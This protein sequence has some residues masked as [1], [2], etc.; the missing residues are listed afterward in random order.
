V[1]LLLVTNK[2]NTQAHKLSFHQKSRNFNFIIFPLNIFQTFTNID[3]ND[4]DFTK[5][6]GKGKF[7]LSTVGPD[8]QNQFWVRT[9]E[10]CFSSHSRTL[11]SGSD[12]VVSDDK[13]FSKSD[14]SNNIPLA[15]GNG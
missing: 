13:N 12:S 9:F 14:A 4:A 7:Q 8:Q 15:I 2:P 5:G 11:I 1:P 6:K 10:L 3:A